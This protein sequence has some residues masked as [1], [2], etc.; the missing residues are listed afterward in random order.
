MQQYFLLTEEAGLVLFSS[1]KKWPKWNKILKQ[2]FVLLIKYS[3]TYEALELEW[4]M[5]K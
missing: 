2:E 1:L 5:V 4:F 3:V